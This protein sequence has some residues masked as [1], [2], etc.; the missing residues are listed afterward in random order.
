MKSFVPDLN[1]KLIS[2]G[3]KLIFRHFYQTGNKT[4]VLSRLIN[5]LDDYFTGSENFSYSIHDTFQEKY[6]CE[7]NFELKVEQEEEK[8][9][10]LLREDFISELPKRSSI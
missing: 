1:T 7:E 3:E 6:L 4:E 2:N 10:N 9:S 8:L 5:Q